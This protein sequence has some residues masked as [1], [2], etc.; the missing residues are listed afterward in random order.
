MAPPT[1][2]RL[3]EMVIV[4]LWRSGMRRRSVVEVAC[5]GALRTILLFAVSIEMMVKVV[6]KEKGAK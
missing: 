4:L 2:L 6:P 1:T 5:A 3:S